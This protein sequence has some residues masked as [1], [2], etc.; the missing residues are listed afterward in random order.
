M[1]VIPLFLTRFAKH[2]H[3]CLREMAYDD[4]ARQASGWIPDNARIES[5]P[6][7]HEPIKLDFDIPKSRRLSWISRTMNHLPH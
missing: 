2:A 1:T 3:H 4:M 5:T 7:R 6:R